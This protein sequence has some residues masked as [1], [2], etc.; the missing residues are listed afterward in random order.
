MMDIGLALP[1]PAEKLVPHRPPLCLIARLLECDGHTGVVEAIIAED[2]IFLKQ[3]G[4]LPSLILAELIAQASAAVKGYDDL[5]HGKEIKKGFLVDIREM[6]FTERCHK[7]DTLRIRIEILR[8]ISGFSVIKGQV[9]KGDEVAGSGT[10][11]IWVP[12][13]GDAPG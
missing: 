8:T 9:E 3:D 4:S 2:N 10:I 12:E 5:I 13:D 1:M 6:R 7:G 11:K